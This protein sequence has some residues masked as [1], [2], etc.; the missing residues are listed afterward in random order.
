[1]RLMVIRS[2]KK[3]LVFRLALVH[4]LVLFIFCLFA[5]WICDDPS[6]Y[7]IGPIIH[8]SYENLDLSNK[9][10]KPNIS[11]PFSGSH[12]FGTDYLGRDVFAGI[13]Y[14]T[15]NTFLMSFI[16]IIIAT[17]FGVFFGMVTGYYGDNGL[18]LSIASLIV[19]SVILIFIVHLLT[20]MF[21][22]PSYYI[23]NAWQFIFMTGG[24]IGILTL[25]FFILKKVPST[26][27]VVA[28][29][30]DLVLNRF[31]DIYVSIPQIFIVLLL[32]VILPPSPFLFV[33]YISIGFWSEF[34]LL[35]RAEMLKIRNQNYILAQKAL[36]L[37]SFKILVTHALPNALTPIY[38][39]FVFAFAKAMILEATLSFI[40]IGLS[41]ETA[42]WG[43]LA[44][45][46]RMDY[47]AWWLAVFPGII[48]FLT[49]NSLHIIGRRFERADAY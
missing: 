34:A 44:A 38:V 30:L 16:G 37:R 18:K 14:G 46:Y 1:M 11:S 4:I 17:V 32:V 22:Y 15:R 10:M 5:E 20:T 49:V 26:R 21:R 40:G 48:I 25:I 47:T 36:G 19:G 41:A 23:F 27:K 9:F 7:H 39:L 42:S 43:K 29:P 35:T 3:S 33:V 2:H 13:I 6:D 24:I 12:I 31:L 8:Y 45:A 28:I